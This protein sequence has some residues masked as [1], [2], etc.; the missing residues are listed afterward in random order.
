MNT[1]ARE[2][3]STNIEPVSVDVTTPAFEAYAKFREDYENTASCAV[4]GSMSDSVTGRVGTISDAAVDKMAVVW[5]A[6]KYKDLG[7]D[8]TRADIEEGAT[9]KFDALMSE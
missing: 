8:I 1:M 5:L 4:R 7:H 2:I 9:T 6:E 3:E